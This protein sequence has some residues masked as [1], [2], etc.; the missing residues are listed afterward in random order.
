MSDSF[1]QA[2]GRKLIGRTSAQ[3]LGTVAHLLVDAHRRHIAAVVVGRGKRARL[4][5]WDALSGFGPDAVMVGDDGALRPPADDRERL[6]ADG[7][8]ELLG[9]RALTELGNEI[10]V[11]DDVTFDTGTGAL[12]SLQVGDREVPAGAMLGCGSYAVVLA[13]LAETLT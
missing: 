6:A 9:R 8:L 13:D 12:E 3:E 10:G 7:K 5:D 4:V 1:R 11:V 2:A